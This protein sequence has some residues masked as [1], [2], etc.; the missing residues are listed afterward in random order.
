VA[1]FYILG[2]GLVLA[3]PQKPC[4]NLAVR[5]RCPV[6]KCWYLFKWPAVVRTRVVT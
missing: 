1:K 2:V 6:E 4:P 3:A 5:P